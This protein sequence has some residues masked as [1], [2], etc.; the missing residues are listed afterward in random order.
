MILPGAQKNN[1]D[2]DKSVTLVTKLIDHIN[3]KAFQSK[4]YRPSN[5][6]EQWASVHEA[7]CGQTD[8]CENITFPRGR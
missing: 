3:K 2:K 1:Q 5:K 6:A 4:A 7:D 8:S